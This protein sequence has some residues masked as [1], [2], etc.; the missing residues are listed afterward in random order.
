MPSEAREAGD[1]EVEED[2]A[3]GAR[4]LALTRDSTVM[5]MVNFARFDFSERKV[6]IRIPILT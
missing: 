4:G 5:R 1:V 2:A 6:Y 3:C